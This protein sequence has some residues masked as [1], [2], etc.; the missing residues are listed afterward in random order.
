[1][2]WPRLTLGLRRADMKVG[3]RILSSLALALVCW[4]TPS[5]AFFSPFDAGLEGW[6]TDN[7]GAFTFQ[8][9]G[10][11]PGG[12]LQ[13][14][15]NELQIAHIFAP[16]PFLGDLSFLA[17]VAA[18]IGFDGQLVAGGGS[19]YDAGDDYGRIRV[20][21]G[22]MSASADLLP[23]GA[24]PPLGSWQRY[25]VPFTAATF[26]VSQG[27]W[28]AIL[29]NVTEIRITVE[30]LFGS[31]I[32]GIDNVCL[33]E[34]P[35]VG[36][37]TLPPTSS[38]SSTTSSS[39]SSTTISTTTTSSTV[40]SVTTTSSTTTTVASTSTTTSSTTTT[41]PETAELLP[42]TKLL[43][44]QKKSGAQRLQLIVRDAGVGVS[45]PCETDGA[46]VIEAG[47][48]TS[49]FELAAD[50]WKPIKSKRPEKG[51]KYRKGPVVATALLKAG[52]MLRV[53]ANAENLGVSLSADPR[54]IR[55]EVRH[56]DARH[57]VEFG[58]TGPFKAGKKLLAK[59]AG[60]PSACPGS[61]SPIG[62]FLD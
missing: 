2:S 50:L 57:C 30:G 59:K 5:A 55:I 17:N 8:A 45:T 18:P 60:P 24:V 23:N 47:G 44:K 11:N 37:T 10:G 29:A 16:G 31:E 26:G 13:L 4:A 41:L 22:G 58:G 40:T 3:L 52:K 15:N 62:A 20:T 32:Q 43:L 49:I 48:V 25:Q 51:C 6:T 36:T 33:S 28:E 38:T 56:G 9:N 19:L 34:C 14:D 54:P 21:G 35:F 12:F 7:G 27:V 46:L 39:S 53:T 42:G 1:M 61:P